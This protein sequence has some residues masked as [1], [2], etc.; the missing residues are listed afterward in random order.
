MQLKD[1]RTFA[2]A[3]GTQNL[4]AAA[5]VLGVTQPA[6]SKSIRRLED[7]LGGKVF[8]RTARGVALTRVGE[9]LY[10]RSQALDALVNDI[11]TEIGDI[12]A[13]TSALVRLGAVPIM[14]EPV[15]VPTL[16]R[17][18]SGPSP[19]RFDVHVQLS[20]GLLRALQAGE[21][22]L[23]IAAM[24]S[25]R[26]AD[27]TSIALG[28]GRSYVVAAST[29]PM[30]KKA[31]TLADLAR[32][33]WLLPPPDLALSQWIAGV[34]HDAGL[35]LPPYTVQSDASPSMFTALVRSTHLLSVM[36]EEL[37]E[38][39]LGKGLVALPAPAPQRQVQ[40]GLFWRRKAFFTEPMQR[41][42]AEVK[43]V[44]AQWRP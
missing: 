31:F 21:L 37:L 30:L 4:R 25:E 18:T 27:L 8:E 20:A 33:Q 17:L 42:R 36:T 9:V 29:H 11:Q 39:G 12:N 15:V 16:A 41:C 38:S 26:P 10:R 32:Q 1:L 5:D 7:A 40:M 2:V 14:V 3:A 6:V 43:G 44:F 19:L 35:V 24:P 23:A 22:D 28:T 34:F 13:G